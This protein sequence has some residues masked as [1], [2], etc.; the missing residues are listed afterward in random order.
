LQTT[1]IIKT[2]YYSAHNGSPQNSLAPQEQLS[3]HTSRRSSSLLISRPVNASASRHRSGHPRRTWK[4]R[5]N[6]L[7]LSPLH[8]T[9]EFT[10][11]TK[12]LYP[13]QE[14]QDLAL[15]RENRR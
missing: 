14:R 13:V 8:F 3:N 6:P 10:V 15:S 12:Y 2:A 4:R 7:L 5:P 9:P 11:G 1:S